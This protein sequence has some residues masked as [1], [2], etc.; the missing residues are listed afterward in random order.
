ML[1]EK[2]HENKEDKLISSKK[3]DQNKSNKEIKVK[4]T[5]VN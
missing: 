4:Q 3:N 1:V 5:E 2:T